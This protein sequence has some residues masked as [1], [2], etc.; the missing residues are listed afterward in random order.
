MDKEVAI[1]QIMIV[2]MDLGRKV[3]FMVQ[4]FSTQRNEENG[5]L[6]NLAKGL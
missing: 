5:N 3:Y 1:F 4:E 2:T 6:E